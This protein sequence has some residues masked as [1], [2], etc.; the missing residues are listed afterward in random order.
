MKCPFCGAGVTTT[1]RHLEL[2]GS[3]ALVERY[4]S[5]RAKPSEY[6]HCGHTWKTREEYV[7]TITVS[8]Y[9]HIDASGRIIKYLPDLGLPFL[10]DSKAKSPQR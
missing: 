4:Y 6:G 10:P 7:G 2:T 1:T 8:N 3:I 9:G 5:C